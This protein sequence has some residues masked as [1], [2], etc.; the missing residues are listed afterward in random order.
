VA[1]H[2]PLPSVA[3]Q[4]LLQKRLAEPALERPVLAEAGEPAIEA[5]G[6]DLGQRPPQ[7]G[8][9]RTDI[10]SMLQIDLAVRVDEQGVVHPHHRRQ[11]PQPPRLLGGQSG[12]LV[13][14]TAVV[15][16]VVAEG[17]PHPAHEVRE[18]IGR[19]QHQFVV[20]HQRDDS[21]PALRGL[22]FQPHRQVDAGQPLRSA[23]DQVAHQDQGGVPTAPAPLRI[24]QAGAVE[25]ANEGAEVTVQVAENE[26][27]HGA[28]CRIARRFRRRA[29]C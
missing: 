13:F 20:A 22:P 26:G 10:A 14:D 7:P 3:A 12:E 4:E 5:R 25:E 19:Q 6:I 17:L 29:A 8:V 1:V 18:R 9:D 16:P 2:Q 24:D 15:E 21:A 23:I 28:Q 11:R 27:G